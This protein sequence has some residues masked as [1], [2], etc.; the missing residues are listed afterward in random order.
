MAT[1]TAELSKQEETLLGDIMDWSLDTSCSGYEGDLEEEEGEANGETAGDG[2]CWWGGLSA[3]ISQ[4]CLFP[5]VNSSICIQRRV[6][7]ESPLH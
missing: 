4:K 7:S 6:M 3:F 5:K 1:P 2:K